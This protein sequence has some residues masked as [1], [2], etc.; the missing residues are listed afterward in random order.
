MLEF[1]TSEFEAT[2]ALKATIVSIWFLIET[3]GNGLFFG[4]IHF[5]IFAGDPLKRRITD[6]V[7]FFKKYVLYVHTN[8]IW[9]YQIE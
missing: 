1:T 4:L 3:F 6:Q 9:S 7:S 8:L 2:T 5:D